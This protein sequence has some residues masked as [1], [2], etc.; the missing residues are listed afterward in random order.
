MISVVEDHERVLRLTEEAPAGAVPD[1][2]CATNLITSSSP[3]TAIRGDAGACT[4]PDG[5]AL[6]APLDAAENPR[7][8]HAWIATGPRA[9]FHLLSWCLS[10]AVLSRVPWPPSGESAVGGYRGAGDVG[11]I[12]RWRETQRDGRSRRVWR[13]R[14]GRS[15]GPGRNVRVRRASPAARMAR[16]Q[17]ATVAGAMS[18]WPRCGTR[19]RRR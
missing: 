18:R 10:G 9:G 14:T 2:C 16:D 6:Q 4:G 19:C 7:I 17:P 11:G 1:E 12:R 8:S 13:T 5:V 15:C 3:N